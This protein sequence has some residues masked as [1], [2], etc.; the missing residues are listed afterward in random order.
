LTKVLDV[1]SCA[2]SS[3]PSEARSPPPARR[4]DA[5][6]AVEC[7]SLQLNAGYPTALFL[8]GPVD[9]QGESDTDC[10]VRALHPRYFIGWGQGLTDSS[11]DGFFGLFFGGILGQR[12]DA[13]S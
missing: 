5:Q 4:S 10:S 1:M 12:V 3:P 2:L 13:C 6:N 8:N 9:G 11:C 7:A